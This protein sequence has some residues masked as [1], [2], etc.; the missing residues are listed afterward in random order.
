[1]RL[2]HRVALVAL[3]GMLPLAPGYSLASA[4]NHC[5]DA[6]APIAVAA[7]PQAAHAGHEM[8]G[9]ASTPESGEASPEQQYIDMMIPHHASIIALAEVAAPDLTDPR[10]REMATAIIAT[11]E[12]EIAELRELR[13]ARFG[14]PD[15]APLDHALMGMVEM[16]AGAQIAAFCAA[17][18]PDI[19]FARQTL[20]HHELAVASSRDLL[21]ASDD[22]EL[23]AL[24]ERVI[25]AQAA[26]IATLQ[27]VLRE[28]SEATPAP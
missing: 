8:S 27:Q 5:A 19:A 16:D 22:A 24:A 13:Q 15:P 23:R 14:S 11:Q 18:D 6:A 20:P 7:T 4:N 12:A 9:P 10:L 25:S 2:I 3:S 28:H 1:M 21:D 26:E 17:P